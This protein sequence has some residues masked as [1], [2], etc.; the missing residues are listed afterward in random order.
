MGLKHRPKREP[1]VKT[2]RDS[3]RAVH[4]YYPMGD[5]H[6]SAV[7]AGRCFK[8][9][10]I[11]DCFCDNCSAWACANHLEKKNELDFCEN[12]LD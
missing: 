8:C 2:A 5:A 3:R 12:C 10:K 11:T 9:K 7:P 4:K 6:S 1:T